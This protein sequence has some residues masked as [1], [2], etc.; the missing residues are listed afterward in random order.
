MLDIVDWSNEECGAFGGVA[1]VEV[2]MS[3]HK[4]VKAKEQDASSAKWSVKT[5]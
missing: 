5:L 1:E 4:V 2:I 3:D